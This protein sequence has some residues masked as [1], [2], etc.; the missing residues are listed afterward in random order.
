[1]AQQVLTDFQVR[2]PTMGNLHA[3]YNVLETCDI[4]DFGAPDITLDDLRN[5]WRSPSYSLDENAWVVTTSDEKIIAFADV[6]E[7]EHVRNFAYVRVL[8]EYAGTGIYEYLLQ[9]T[10]QWARRQISLARPDAR[11]SLSSWIAPHNE[12]AR[13]GLLEQGFQEIRRH[14]RMEIEFHEVPPAPQWPENITVR[15]FQPGEERLVFDT[16]EEA[17]K[18]HWGHLPMDFERWKHWTI[19]RENFDPTLWFLAFEGYRI[20]GISLCKREHEFGWVDTLGVLRPWRRQG[21]GMALLL[22]SFNEFYRR[23]WRKAG[24]GVDSQ[25]LTGATRLYER[26]GM[27]V[28]RTFVTYEKELRPGVELSTQ[29]VSV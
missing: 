10:E 14:W 25:N 26:A 28:A 20:A 9:Q 23:G 4:A 29:T 17:F 5:A 12:A 22:H 19:E 2:R 21:L 16:D 27:H 11:V 3:V 7:L 6:E 1:M 18:D 15:T 24:L 8:P 13:R